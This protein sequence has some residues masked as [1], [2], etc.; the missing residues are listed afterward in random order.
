MTRL[1]VIPRRTTSK[2]PQRGKGADHMIPQRRFLHGCP[3]PPNMAEPSV[4]VVPGS[5]TCHRQLAYYPIKWTFDAWPQT[6]G[7]SEVTRPGGMSHVLHEQAVLENAVSSNH[8][9]RK[10]DEDTYP[11]HNSEH[12][13]T[14]GESRTSIVFWKPQ[15]HDFANMRNVSYLHT[16]RVVRRRR[17]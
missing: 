8:Q 3:L 10:A 7:V 15:R 5:V 17:C 16:H 11:C 14:G 12:I 4:S 13:K 6:H 1:P 2:L 9:K